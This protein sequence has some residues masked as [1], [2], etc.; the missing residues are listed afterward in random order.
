MRLISKAIAGLR[1][2][3]PLFASS[4][5]AT[6]KTFQITVTNLTKGQV[7][8]PVLMVSHNRRVALFELGEPASDGLAQLAEG[9]ATRPI[10]DAVA[11]NRNV[12]GTAVSDGPVPPG[13]SVTIELSSK[14]ASRISLASM[15]VNTNDAFV[16]LN[17]VYAP[18]SYVKHFARAYDAGSEENDELC[19]NIPGPLCAGQGN[20]QGGVLGEEGE[21]YIY[22]RNGVHGIGNIAPSVADWNNPVAKITIQRIRNRR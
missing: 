1:I 2:S 6:N 18:R 16:A 12:F 13:Q 7:F 15:L 10:I 8:S 20:E 5:H 9:G 14:F 21:G 19:V 11:D 3:I 17:S 22:T 4:A